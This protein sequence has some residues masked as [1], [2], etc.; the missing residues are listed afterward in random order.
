MEDSRIVRFPRPL[1]WQELS[2]ITSLFA[3]RYPFL[4][5][6]SL[7]NSI[8]GKSIP[9]FR[10]GNGARHALYVGAHHGMEWIT[11]ILLLR[12]VNEFCEYYRTQKTVYRISL[13][14]F[15]EEFTLHV[16]PMLNP[17]GVDYQIHGV[18]TENP[19]RRRVLDMNGGSEDF[20]SWQANARGVDLN[21]NYD[22]GFAEYKRIEA[23]A[24]IPC[25]APTRYSG[26]APESEPEVRA[27]CDYIRFHA[28]IKPIL[29][30][31][32]QGEEIYYRSGG[33]TLPGT[34]AAAQRISKL[35]GYRLSDAEG[36]ASYGGLTD[37]CIRML[38]IPAVTLECGRGQNPLPLSSFFPI[39]AGLREVLFTAPTLY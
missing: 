14:I 5:V 19:L 23:E 4:T 6:T 27:L 2:R 9:V 12:F 1:D 13:P 36:L 17:D 26:Q 37:W 8:L 30:L 25:G 10:L 15:W 22:A 33:K 29:T 28:S 31:H 16:I 24:S 34:Y 3:E 7:G 18:D 39:Y 21:H 35:S 32:T 11:G 38:G 20:S